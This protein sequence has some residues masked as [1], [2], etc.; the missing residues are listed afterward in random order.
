MLFHATDLRAYIRW[1]KEHLEVKSGSLIVLGLF[2][3]TVVAAGLI[4][5][6]FYPQLNGSDYEMISILQSL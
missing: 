3:V 2:F 1:S 6:L 4:N 5:A